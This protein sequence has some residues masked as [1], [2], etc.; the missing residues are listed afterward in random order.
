MFT[1]TKQTTESTNIPSWVGGMD[2]S[3]PLYG[4]AVQSCIY[5]YNLLPREYGMTVRPGTL[6]W[7]NTVEGGDVKTVIPYNAPDSADAKLFC[8]T[9]EGIYDI[10]IPSQ[11][12][13]PQ[14]LAWVSTGGVAG[15]VYFTGYV[16]DATSFI[17]ACDEENGYHTYSPGTGWIAGTLTNADGFTE[18]EAVFVMTWK[19]RAFFARKN[20][21]RAYYLPVAAVAGATSSFDFG[22]RFSHGGYLKALYSWSID[23]G[24]GLD[25]YLVVVGSEGDCLVY[26]GT[27]PDSAT[28]F[29]LVGSFYLGKLPY[30]RKIATQLGGDLLLLSVYGAISLRDLLRGTPIEQGNV[31]VTAKI[32]KLVR[33]LMS[34]ASQLFGWSMQVYANENLLIIT[35][36]VGATQ[37]TIQFAMD[38]TTKAW[39]FM[40]DMDILC[41]DVWQ[42]SMF[43]GY[44][45]GQVFNFSG[46]SDKVLI[47][48]TPSIAI[49]YSVLGSFQDLGSP[50]IFKRAQFLRPTFRGGAIPA[51][52]IK[53]LYDYDFVEPLFSSDANPSNAGVWQSSGIVPPYAEDVSLW[54]SAAW[55]G[56]LV[57]FNNV[58]GGIGMGRTMAVA[59][60]GNAKSEQQ[61]VDINI[62]WDAG[63]P[64]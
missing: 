28:D 62:L 6:E 18:G 2:A 29:G 36:P 54:D 5:S 10:S 55:S 25:D 56:A 20:S 33:G 3:S 35:V 57:P 64:L 41:C 24:A 37:R 43:F 34:T 50:A 31:Y 13:P 38:T 45:D 8:A 11:I 42:E 63:G 59:I 61:L 15:E 40:R 23:G 60:I 16:N 4:M 32:S 51:Y 39:S 26:Q 12:N 53:A 1:A 27:D 19:N 44:P 52:S 48:E 47:D 58:T 49:E 30:G 22:N 46:F 7:A 21:S 17:L 14:A 9:S